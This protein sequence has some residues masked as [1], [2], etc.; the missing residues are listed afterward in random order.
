M[1]MYIIVFENVFAIKSIKL[2]PM[3][4]VDP[5][6]ACLIKEGPANFGSAYSRISQCWC[7]KS[8]QGQMII[9]DNFLMKAKFF[10]LFQ[11]QIY[12]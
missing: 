11:F 6:M 2:P 3:Q 8:L 5:K 10:E 12:K 4:Y 1:Y 7:D 9:S